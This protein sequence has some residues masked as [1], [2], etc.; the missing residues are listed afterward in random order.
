M[1]L[2]HVNPRETS[3]EGRPALSI[4]W[5]HHVPIRVKAHTFLCMLAYYVRWHM[6]E[7]WRPLLF[8]DEDLE[9]KEHRDPVAPAKRSAG[10]MR[11]LATR[12]LEDGTGVHSFRTLLRS[13]STIVRNECRRKGASDGEGT[14]SM[15]TTPSAEQQRALDLLEQISV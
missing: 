12:K 1:H 9:A 10:A 6:L 11:K 4:S 13:L 15:E 8:A 3:G 2:N 5:C 7:A 14:F